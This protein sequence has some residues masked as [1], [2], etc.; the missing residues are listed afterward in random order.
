DRRTV[1]TCGVLQRYAYG[2]RR[3]QRFFGTSGSRGGPNH[4]SGLEMRIP[5]SALGW[6]ILRWTLGVLL[7]GAAVTKLLSVDSP[8]YHLS[9]LWSLVG[10][11][12]TIA[13][14]LFFLEGVFGMALIAGIH[15]R[16]SAL[17]MSIGFIA[18]AVGL[19]VQERASPRH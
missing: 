16:L 7:L 17:L 1:P 15:V 10:E 6:A 2:Q 8:D 3:R 19:F 14:A 11:N 9:A 12:R 5:E 4:G 18:V 13:I